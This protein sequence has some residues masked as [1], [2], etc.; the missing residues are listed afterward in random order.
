MRLTAF[1]L[2]V[3]GNVWGGSNT[4][5]PSTAASSILQKYVR[6]PLSFE[7][8]GESEFVA[9]GQGYMVDVLGSRVTIGSAPSNTVGLE[10][11]GSHQSTA[12]PAEEL[13]GRVN[14]ILGK[15]PRRWRI[16]LPTYGR[17]TYRQIYPGIDV[18]YYGNQQQLE[19]D[20][21][22][23]AGADVR[24]IRMR[25]NGGVTPRIDAAG[26]LVLGD[27]RLPVPSVIQGSRS[28]PVKYKLLKHAE[29]T[30]ELGSYD[31]NRPLTIDPTLVY[32]T[33]LGGGN[34]ANLGNSVA[35]DANGNAYVVGTTYAGDFP[36]VSPAFGGYNANG[37]GV[38]SKVN[39]TG[40]ALLYS[41]Y[42]GG[43]GSD[44]FKAIA[45][46]STGAAWAVGNSTSPDFPLLSPY[47]ST[48]SGDVDAVVVKLTPGGALAYSTF[49]GA[50]GYDSANAVAVDPFGNAYVTG[51][52]GAGFPTTAG[53]YQPVI[54]GG[55]ASFVTKFGSDATLNWSTFV[56]GTSFDYA[57]G[58]AVDQFGNTYITG[59]SYSAAL[60]GAPPAGAQPFN[61]GNGDAFVAKLNF[62][63]SA[64][65]YF[66][67]LGGSDY[68]Q[69]N[70]IAVDQTSGV[71][72]IAGQTQSSDLP[73]T[74][75]AVQPA[76]AGALD[77]FVAK[78]NAAGSTFVYATYLGGNRA[79]VLNGVGIDPNGSAYVVGYTHSSTFP[80]SVPIQSSIQGNSTSVFSS[81]NAGL[82]WTP[83]DT[84][85]P[86]VV[87]SISPDPA[88]GGTIIASTESG[89]YQTANRGITWVQRLPV[90][91]NLSRSPANK[92]V[93]YGEAG[94][95][96][97]QSID[98]GLTWGY[99]G[100]M[101]FCCGQDIGGGPDR[102]RHRLYLGFFPVARAENGGQRRQ[103]DFRKHRNPAEP[104]HREDG[105][106]RR[107]RAVCRS[108]KQRTRAAL[109]GYLQEFGS[110]R[111]LGFGKRRIE[112]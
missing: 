47:Q 72:V 82:S 69:A 37:D 60:P 73:T 40:T 89:I 27:L 59:V 110:W 79:D 1:V 61:R 38:I 42:I 107:R 14:Y 45:V 74:P 58:I 111:D 41:T 16:G 84:N 91:L 39:S 15:D 56:G 90:S 9:R 85:L 108:Q 83:F 32:S 57:N 94:T 101:P 10:F 19:F 2:L 11:V 7:R 51:Q 62:N 78:L 87:S 103:L 3:C 92:S 17:V 13:P 75:G 36:T 70:A 35:L 97:Y 34:S 65:L 30:F 4:T 77:G 28:V 98:R 44:T 71:A 5:P 66:T 55:T 22:L 112:R 52:T 86:G 106:C 33:R 31:R 81:S 102:R 43:S 21:A 12:V 24:S 68:D 93:I 109:S 20:L 25:F 76:A 99:Q 29:V 8:T 105:R 67:F 26:T 6:I 96:V 18:V 64:L 100:T 53:V 80:A 63:G 104:E 95:S 88:D 50:A 49:L 46:D 23:Q 54:Q 48:L